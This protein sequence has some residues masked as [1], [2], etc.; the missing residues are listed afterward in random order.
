MAPAPS[1]SL[2]PSSR[3]SLAL[4]MTTA[5]WSRILLI[6]AIR[7]AARTAHHERGQGGAEGF[8][9]AQEGEVT[10]QGHLS[11]QAALDDGRVQQVGARGLGGGQ[12]AGVEA[13]GR[14]VNGH[15]NSGERGSEKA[16]S[17]AAWRCSMAARSGRPLGVASPASGV[18]SPWA[19]TQWRTWA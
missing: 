14:G 8:R 5:S 11:A 19:R 15:G 4:A 10:R 3:W 9:L 2:N 17:A 12:Q 6:S 18:K 7:V 16:A 1:G 13:G